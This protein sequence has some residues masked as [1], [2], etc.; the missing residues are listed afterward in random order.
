MDCQVPSVKCQISSRKVP[1]NTKFDNR[2]TVGSIRSAGGW[3]ISIFYRSKMVPW[4]WF[5]FVAPRTNK[6]YISRTLWSHFGAT[7]VQ[8]GPKISQVGAKME[9][10]RGQVGANLR[11]VGPKLA[12]FVT[13]MPTWAKLGSTCSHL[14]S[15]CLHLPALRAEKD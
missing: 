12:Q 10:S 8:V 14:G 1:S 9:P 7:L 4:L 13:K 15:T 3:Q 6:T 5:F 2:T 11:Q